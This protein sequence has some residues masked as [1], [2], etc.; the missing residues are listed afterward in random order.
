MLATLALIISVL[1]LAGAIGWFFATDFCCWLAR[2]VCHG[3]DASLR[4][5]IWHAAKWP[6]FFLRD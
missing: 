1:Y 6:I 5:R 2:T 3:N 4:T